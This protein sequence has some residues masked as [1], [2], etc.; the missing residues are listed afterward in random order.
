MASVKDVRASDRSYATCI[1]RTDVRAR[2][3][4]TD[5]TAAW[6]SPRRAGVPAFGLRMANV[7]ERAMNKGAAG[8]K[9]G[10]MTGQ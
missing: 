2:F 9:R 8:E 10:T 3:S 6:T 4:F 5:Q 1:V 7:T